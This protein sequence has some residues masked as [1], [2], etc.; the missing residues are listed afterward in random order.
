MI[1][2]SQINLQNIAIQ[3]LDE[4]PTTV[5]KEFEDGYIDF[6]KHYFEDIESYVRV[7]DLGPVLGSDV[8]IE[9]VFD[10]TLKDL[11]KYKKNYI[12]TYWDGIYNAAETSNKI[13]FFMFEDG[14]KRTA[15]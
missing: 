12:K 3:I 5:S 13:I 4:C 8:D 11:R 1:I 10:S 9:F 6:V 7:L 15:A 2:K 14:S